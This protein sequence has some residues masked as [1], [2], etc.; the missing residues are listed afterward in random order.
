VKAE[1]LPIMFGDSCD[2]FVSCRVG[3][4]VLTSEIVKNSQKPVYSAR[5]KF[6]LFYPILNDRIVIRVWDN[7]RMLSNIYIGSVPEV[8]SENDQFNINVL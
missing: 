8:P 1:G 2:S 7:R 4:N 3:G 6:P 5:M